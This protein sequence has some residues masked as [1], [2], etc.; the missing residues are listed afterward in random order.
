MNSKK[1]F[2]KIIKVLPAVILL[3]FLYFVYR[4]FDRI[5]SLL[6][7]SPRSIVILAL[8]VLAGFIVL[9]LQNLIL[10]RRFNVRLSLNE[11]VGLA[12]LNSI[13]TFL[14]PGGGLMVK[15]LYLKI[16]HFLALQYFISSATVLFVC[17]IGVGGLIGLA[18]TGVLEITEHRPHS[19]YLLYGFALMTAASVFIWVPL[20]RLWL[21]W[22]VRKRLALL[23]QGWGVLSR[24]PGM[25]LQQVLLQGLSMLLIA[26]R[27]YFAFHIL[28]QEVLLVHGLLFSAAS[29]LTRLVVFVPGGLGVRE[30]LVAGVAA[31]LGFDPELSVLAAG[32]DRLVATLVILVLACFQGYLL[33]E[34]PQA[35]PPNPDGGK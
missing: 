34:A 14:A 21:P 30:G 9:G 16:R 33:K 1:V 4:N 31:L 11:S 13:S 28:S 2:G 27:L 8:L 7:I 32:I 22:A 35:V 19:A 15:G 3:A 6:R 25:L 23:G 29:I 26:G 5:T 20:D 10:Y 17:Y 18:S 24:S 12:V